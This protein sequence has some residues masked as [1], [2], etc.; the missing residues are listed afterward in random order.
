MKVYDSCTEHWVQSSRTSTRICPHLAHQPPASAYAC[1]LLI[2]F[3]QPSWI[4]TKL[5]LYWNAI[6]VHLL[7]GRTIYYLRE[8]LG[9]CVTFAV[10][11]TTCNSLRSRFSEIKFIL[12]VCV[13]FIWF[14]LIWWHKFEEVNSIFA[15]YFI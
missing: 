7:P 8:N 15:W 3:L 13:V 1:P 4:W 11:A 5:S 2:G 6:S 9:D 12:I 14:H 10:I